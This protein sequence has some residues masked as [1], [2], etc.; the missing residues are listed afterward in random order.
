MCGIV[1]VLQRLMSLSDAEFATRIDR[2]RDRMEHRGPDA[3]GTWVDTNSGIGLGHRRLSIIDLSPAGAQP[4]ESKNGRYVIVFNGEIYNFQALRQELEGAGIIF[5]GHSD[6][7]VLLE[8]CVVWGARKMLTRTNGMFALAL[9]DKERRQLLLARDRM[10]EKPLYYGCF[11]GMFLFASELKA[12]HGWPGFHPELDRDALALFM[13]TGYIP[14][15]WCIYHGLRKLPP[16]HFVCIQDPNDQSVH[17]EAYWSFSQAIEFGVAKPSRE[18]P[19]EAIAQLDRRLRTAVALRMV[20]DVPLGAFLSGG[21]DSSTIVALMQAQS[22]Q[23]IRTFS[24]G[25]DIPEFDESNYARAVA[26]HLGTAH[27]QLMVSSAEAREVIPLIAD[28]YDEPFADSSQIPTYLVSKLA[29]TAVTVAMSGDAGDELFGGYSRY[30]QALALWQRTTRIPRIA[31]RLIAAGIRALPPAHWDRIM[32]GARPLVPARFRYRNP[33]E[34]LYKFAR[35]L[36]H[37]TPGAMYKQLVSLWDDPG[38]LVLGSHEPPTALDRI[39]QVPVESFVERMMA[40]DTQHYLP[41]DILVKVDRA[42]MAVS[43]ESRV[44]FLDHDIVEYAWQLPL[45]FKARAGQGKWILRRVLERYVPRALFERPKMGFGVPIGEWLRGPLREWAE[46]LLSASRLEQAGYL[47][48]RVVRAIWD[49]HLTGEDNL[50]YQIWNVLMFEQWRTR[51][52][53]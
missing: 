14:D 41:G 13:R 4:M 42:S 28:I 49:S 20:A 6:T 32:I 8:G 40:T 5:K 1:G 33:G 35:M 21:I 48:P 7:E 27:T 22:T 45:A 52:G 46:D 31:Q 36:S 30:T 44:P 17:E 47:N 51:W 37:R 39:E 53:Y 16:G 24:I 15:P 2:M 25:F 10:G 11:G 34:K 12:L 23:A 43:L 50:Q 19:T 29:R 18:T 9:W 26:A 38:Q 3:S